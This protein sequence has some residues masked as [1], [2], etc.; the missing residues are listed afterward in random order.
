MLL[1]S[2]VYSTDF[3]ADTLHDTQIT[4]DFLNSIQSLP[5]RL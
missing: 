5:N 4:L 1:L 2:L 3:T